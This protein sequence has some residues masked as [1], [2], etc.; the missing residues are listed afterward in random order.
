MARAIRQG[1]V[2]LPRMAPERSFPACARAALARIGVEQQ[3]LASGQRARGGQPSGDDGFFHS[4][5]IIRDGD[6]H[7]GARLA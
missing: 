1:A 6:D 3:H 7:L 5:P 4:S 2:T